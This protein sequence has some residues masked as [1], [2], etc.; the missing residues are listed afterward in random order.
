MKRNTIII[1]LGVLLALFITFRIYI[2]NMENIKLSTNFTLGEFMR[3]DTAAKMGIPNIPNEVEIDRIKKL[4]VNVLQPLRSYFGLPIKI[5]SGGRVEKLNQAVGGAQTSQHKE[6]EA[7]DFK[8][9]GIPNS[10][11]MSAA[12]ELRLPVDQMID[13]QLYDKNGN[14]KTWIH[15]SYDEGR[16]RNEYLL[17]RNNKNGTNTNYYRA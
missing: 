3:S 16:N 11:I 15:V 17:A 7:A 1:L 4:V 10:R 9:V 12:K 8:I 6:W 2:K 5:T 14:L 13:E